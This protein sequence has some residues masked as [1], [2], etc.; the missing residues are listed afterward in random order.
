MRRKLSAH[1]WILALLACVAPSCGAGE[2]PPTRDCATVIWAKPTGRGDLR[3]QGSWDG[4]A[5]PGTPLLP[6]GDGWFLIELSLPPGEHGYRVV[7]GGVSRLDPFN[8]LTTFHDDEEVS[9]AVAPDCSAPELRVDAVEVRGG[10]VTVRGT[11]LAVPDEAALDPSTVLAQEPGGAQIA[12]SQV[13]PGAGTFTL[14][15]EGLPRG[16]HTLTLA[17]ADVLGRAAAP[18]KAV[19]W[20]APAMPA[21][22]GGLLYHL[23]IDRFRGDGGAPL[24]P[25]AT[26]GSRAGGTLD[27][28]R[29]EIE[30]GTF[31]ELGVTGL[32]LS[33]VYTNP[34]ELRAGRDGRLYEGYHGY[35][36]VEPRGVDPRIGG[37]D[38]LRAV[39]DAAHRRGLR[40]IFDLVPN[41]VYESSARYLDRRNQG[42]FN[43]GPDHC[44]CGGP[45]CGWGDHLQ[46]CWF[47]PYLPDVRW[48]Q[49]DA[50]RT[51]VDD[52]LFWMEAFD[53]DGVRI[54]AVP[55]MPRATT[56]RMAAGLRASAA[57]RRDPRPGAPDPVEGALFSIG[58]VFTGPG[59]LG[60]DTYRYFLGPDGM[61]GAF[62]FPLMW[63]IRDA[64]GAD[65][66]GFDAV[67]AVLAQTDAALRGSGAVLGRM[68]DNHDTSR[69]ISDAIGEG[70]ADPWESP[71]AQPESPDAYARA[72]MA[73]AL[74]LTLP[75]LPVLYY[76]DELALA[77]AGDPDSRRV[78]PDLAALSP[79]QRSVRDL[80]RRLGPLRRCSLALRAGARAPIAVSSDVYAYRRDAGDGSPALVFFSKAPMTTE[81]PLPEGA[82]PPGAYVDVLSGEAVDLAAGGAISLDP[83]TF[84]ILLPAA[85]PCHES[86]LL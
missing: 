22:D 24:S 43:D 72:R 23:M 39:I 85:S 5:S 77:G 74:L 86:D 10:D 17:A 46:T 8:P 71:P 81:L 7:E 61:D 51:G 56:R 50:M 28:V 79:G 66:A 34:I 19:A 82:A 76:G 35:W 20:V 53:A 41:H 57:P 78:L 11:F 54:D 40:V 67:E 37:D 13:D 49:P 1:A 84:K 33:P 32:W 12:A 36:P 18:Q 60:T 65:R 70:A 38:A 25:P 2:G 52:A 69:F 83:L 9:L 6:H 68:V 15:L 48:Q 64:F 16:K 63:A 29:A 73:L 14:S 45:A 62:D 4:W 3:V 80:V 26:P 21:W 55:M 47:A 30:R 58:E 44:V 59:T 75:G 27:G 42:W 31:D